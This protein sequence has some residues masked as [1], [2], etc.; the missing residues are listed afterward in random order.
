[1]KKMKR[2]ILLLAISAMVSASEDTQAQFAFY[3]GTNSNVGMPDYNYGVLYRYVPSTNAYT[4]M[5]NCTAVDGNKIAGLVRVGD[6][7]YGTAMYDGLYGSGTVFSFDLLTGNFTKLAD[8]DSINGKS[9]VDDL[10]LAPNGKL[11]GVTMFGG[12]DNGGVLFS[13][14]PTANT[15]EKLIDFQPGPYYQPMAGMIM[16]SNGNLYGMVSYY[17]GGLFEYNIAQNELDFIWDFPSTASGRVPQGKLTELQ[18]SVFYGSTRYGG[19]GLEGTLFRYDQRTDNHT[20]LKH[21]AGGVDGSWP[22]NGFVHVGDALYGFGNKG[23]DYTKGVF[24][25]YD[26]VQ[27]EYTKLIDLDYPIGA[28]PEN[29][30]LLAAD[31]KIY[32]PTTFGGNLARGSMVSYD[33]STGDMTN[34]YTFNGGEGTYPYNG[35]VEACV[36]PPPTGS[37]SVTLCTGATVSDLDVNGTGVKWYASPTSTTA[38]SAGST[39]S[40]TTYY[41]TQTIQCESSG[42]LAVAVTLQSPPDV[43]VTLEGLT[44]TVNEAGA[45]YQ[46]IDCANNSN[47][48]GAN[49]QSYTA[50]ANGQYKVRVVVGPCVATSTCTSITG[51]SID[52]LDM[53]VVSIFPNPTS[54]DITVDAQKPLQRIE[55]LDNAGRL[56]MAQ[57]V[58]AMRTSLSLVTLAPGSYM[59]RI[60]DAEGRLGYRVVVKE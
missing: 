19:D 45:A 7:L 23:G 34:I 44:M 54:N 29:R 40:A 50:T 55:L 37:A 35:M 32:S 28:S 3:G 51:V 10:V 39:L 13:F 58:M 49:A 57:P 16:G 5:S 56:V 25:K 18:D 17:Y 42:R 41:A 1:M 15:I 9:P 21:F 4:V 46:W 6:M 53:D 33:P 36:T 20:I 31:G 14:D 60:T 47:V 59:L 2:F 52:E 38:L 11:Y 24:F 27:D 26:V 8:F 12:T 22:Q 48:S 43:N 30:P